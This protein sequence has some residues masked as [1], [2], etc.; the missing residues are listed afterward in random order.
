[1]IAWR[2]KPPI[3]W[4]VS[5][6]P[7]AVLVIGLSAT[8]WHAVSELREASARDWE[9]FQHE[10]DLLVSRLETELRRYGQAIMGMRDRYGVH[11]TMSERIWTNY[12]YTIHAPAHYPG[13]YDVGF[14][15]FVQDIDTPPRQPHL[16]A[17]LESMR[18]RLGAEYQLRLP[19]GAEKQHSWYH[20]PVTWHSFSQWRDEPVRA[21]RHYGMDLNQNPDLWAAINWASGQDVPALSGRQHIDPEDA[22][23]TGLFI[24]LPVYRQELD[25]SRDMVLSE[26]DERNAANPQMRRE[27]AQLKRYHFF[28]RGVIFGSIDMSAFLRHHLGTNPPTVTFALYAS[29]NQVFCASPDQLLFDNRQQEIRVEAGHAAHSARTASIAAPPGMWKP[30]LGT[31]PMHLVREL[32]LYG[33]VLSFVMEPGGTLGSVLNGR[34]LGLAAG[35]GVATTLLLSG[36]IAY[37]TRARIKLEAIADALRQSETRL[38]ALLHDRE[39]MSRDLHDGTIQS[40]YAIGLGLGQLGRMMGSVP[41]RE[42]LEASLKELERVVTELRSYLIALDP[43]VSPAQSAGAALGQLVTRLRQTSATELRLT[44]EAGAGEGWPPAAVLDLLQA[45][46]EGIS[47]ALRHG[48][49][50]VVELSLLRADTNVICLTISDNGQ[51]FDPSAKGVEGRGIANMELRAKAWN[52]GLRIESRPGGPSRLTLAFAPN[53]R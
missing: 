3:G 47:N 34:T 4:L 31:S 42:R 28:L 45:A 22:S 12:V 37:Q 9:R 41:E 51:G 48:H 20:F 14:A 13:L 40:I 44:A 30:L 53:R 7:W 17:H 32:R 33:R 8:A 27:V 6:M 39:R 46:R 19:P 18:E 1:M 5:L 24:F 43:G 21:Y 25:R 38:Q 52:G 29:T 36:F 16:A 35:F 11:D 10:T 15:E 50:T 49:A 23:I 26:L 2:S